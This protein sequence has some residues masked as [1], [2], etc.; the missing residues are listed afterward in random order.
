MPGGWFVTFF[1]GGVIASAAVARWLLA[2]RGWETP[3]AIASGAALGPVPVV[4][5]TAVVVGALR[6]SR[7]W[8]RDWN[9][10]WATPFDFFAVYVLAVVVAAVPLA[11]V[12]RGAVACL[13]WLVGCA[14][15]LAA[16]AY[17][18]LRLARAEGRALELKLGPDKLLV[19]LLMWPLDLPFCVLYLLWVRKYLRGT[20]RTG[21]E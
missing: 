3:S 14:L 19:A 5:V 1:W 2:R 12:A 10:G 9:G 17:K 21:A 18:E 6:R 7:F 13:V 8:Q 11:L 16:Q 15:A 4:L 20:R